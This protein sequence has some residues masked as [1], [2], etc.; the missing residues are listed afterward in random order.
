[1][2]VERIV[3]SGEF[4]SYREKQRKEKNE[5]EIDDDENTTPI[6]YLKCSVKANEG[7]LFPLKSSLIFVHK[8][9]VHIKLSSIRYCEFSR[10][11]STCLNGPSSSATRTFDLTVLLKPNN[12]QN[13][14]ESYM[15]NFG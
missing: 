11:L 9:V 2:K 10:V 3:V 14:S 8:P 13:M 7:M 5:T 12:I 6:Q 15:D 4:L 1:M